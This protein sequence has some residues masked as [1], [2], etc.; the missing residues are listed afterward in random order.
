MSCKTSL[1]T[2]RLSLKILA[3]YMQDHQDLVTRLSLANINL[4]LLTNA[5]IIRPVRSFTGTVLVNKQNFSFLFNMLLR[6]VVIPKHLSHLNNPPPTSSHFS[7][8]YIHVATCMT[9]RF[10]YNHLGCV[11]TVYNK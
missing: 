3:M 9:D 4:N 8:L 6:A 2:I 11:I 7:S 5:Y 10:Y 1:V